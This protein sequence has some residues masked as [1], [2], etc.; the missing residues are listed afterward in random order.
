MNLNFQKNGFIK[1]NDVKLIMPEKFKTIRKT[2]NEIKEEMIRLK[3]NKLSEKIDTKKLE[4]MRN[5]WK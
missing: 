2:P 1:N 3:N 4:A 5:L